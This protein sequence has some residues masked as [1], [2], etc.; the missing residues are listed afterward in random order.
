[1]SAVPEII[2]QP[3]SVITIAQ[4]C[5]G[6]VPHEMS[7]SKSSKM[8]EPIE[9]LEPFE[10]A[11]RRSK[12]KTWKMCLPSIIRDSFTAGATD[13]LLQASGKTCRGH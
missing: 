13:I 6:L 11:M 8:K 3:I 9:Q 10:A 1:M 12:T 2:Q 5:H 7:H 4:N